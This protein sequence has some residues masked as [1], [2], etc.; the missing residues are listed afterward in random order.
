MRQHANH[1]PLS[2][3]AIGVCAQ[4]LTVVVVLLAARVEPDKG[5]RSNELYT[6]ASE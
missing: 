3:L 2:S 4:H 6:A 1:L 5:L